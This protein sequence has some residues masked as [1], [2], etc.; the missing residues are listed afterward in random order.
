MGNRAQGAR[1]P[2][3]GK[4]Q[5]AFAN[6]VQAERPQ[7]VV[8]VN[9]GVFTGRAATSAEID[10]LAEWLLDRVDHV[11]IV[12]ETHHEI[13]THSEAAVHQVRIEV[14]GAARDDTPDGLEQWLVERAEL[15]ARVCMAERTA[16]AP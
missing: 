11:T 14:T 4:P 12:S 5:L 16:S 6:H 13:D 15:W 7:V 2:S 1:K 8:R 9:F 3:E 10:R